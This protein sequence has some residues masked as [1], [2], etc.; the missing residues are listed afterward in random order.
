VGEALQINPCIP[1]DWPGYE[2]TYRH[3][4]TT[5]QIHVEN[6]EGVN[7]GVKQVTLDGEA[8]PGGEIPLTGDGQQHEVRVSMG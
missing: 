7:R 5:Y 1:R 8:L 4:E 6:P 3:G 2:L